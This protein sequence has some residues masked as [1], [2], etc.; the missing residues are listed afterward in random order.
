MYEQHEGAD[1]MLN[2]HFTLLL[3]H[4]N[5]VSYYADTL[6]DDNKPL[7]MLFHY[8]PPYEQFKGVR[9]FQ[10]QLAQL[11][12]LE[13]KQY[14]PVIDLSEWLHHETEEYFIAFVKYLA[15]HTSLWQ[16]ILT[17]RNAV[18]AD[19]QPMYLRLRL[20]MTGDVQ[21][22]EFTKPDRLLEL[23]LISQYGMV[24]KDACTLAQIMAQPAFKLYRTQSFLEHLVEEI[25]AFPNKILTDSKLRAYA[26]ANGSLLR[27]ID[28]K[29]VRAV[30]EK[31]EGR[32][33]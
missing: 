22:H 11:N 28:E 29:A 10:Q 15:D 19:V 1:A 9:Q 14:K 13:W 8:T 16:Y 25:N 7:Y 33:Q 26:L 27:L 4:E 24:E 30:L 6:L 21:V 12:P 18:A 20:Y 2:N 3:C 32:E 5:D 23:Q 17:V 31:Q